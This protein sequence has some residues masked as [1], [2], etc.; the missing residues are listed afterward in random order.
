MYVQCMSI[1]GCAVFES[2]LNV[3]QSFCQRV[4]WSVCVIFERKFG[5]FGVYVECVV[6]VRFLRYVE[7]MLCTSS[8]WQ[9]I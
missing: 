6:H 4:T 3:T 8:I 2:I 7:Y 9:S 5:V 1:L